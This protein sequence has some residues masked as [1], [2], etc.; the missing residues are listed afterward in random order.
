MFAIHNTKSGKLPSAANTNQAYGGRQDEAL[1]AIDA[2]QGEHR[3]RLWQVVV[4][5]AEALPAEV[6]RYTTQIQRLNN[7]CRND[8]CNL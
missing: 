8:S 2:A 5:A 4:F 6:I 7:Y 1:V 3:P